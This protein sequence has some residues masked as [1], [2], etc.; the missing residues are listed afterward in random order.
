MCTES[1][2]SDEYMVP[3]NEYLFWHLDAPCEQGLSHDRLDSDDLIVMT[4]KQRVCCRDVQVKRGANCWTDHKL[5]RAKLRVDLPCIYSR[6]EKIL[7]FSVHKLSVLIPGM[8]TGTNWNMFYRISHN[9]RTCP[10]RRSGN[11]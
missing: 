1:V 6:G 4:A 7:P 10:M 9:V 5:V 3:E 11:Y 8:S 2:D